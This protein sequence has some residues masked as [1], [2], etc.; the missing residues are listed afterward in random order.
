MVLSTGEIGLADHMRSARLAPRTMAGQ[1]L[2]LIDLDA[3]AG[4]GMG[5]FEQLHGAAGAAEFA[6]AIKEA[7]AKDYGLAGPLFVRR[8]IA[9]GQPSG[10]RA[11]E[12]LADFVAEARRGGDSGQIHRAALRFG[13]VAAAGELATELGI[14]P[15]PAGTAKAAALSLFNRWAEGFGR[16]G[17]MEE[18]QVI[19]AVRNAIQ[20]HG[21]RFGTVTE[22][23]ADD[24]EGNPSP[25]AGE[26]RSLST[27][28]FVHCIEMEPV[29]LFH[30]AGWEEVLKGF[31]LKFAAKA[32]AKAG[33]LW[34][35]RG[36]RHKKKVRAG[37]GKPEPFYVI[38]AS[39]LEYDEEEGPEAEAEADAVAAGA[40]WAGPE[41]S[42]LDDWISDEDWN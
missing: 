10:A 29:Y 16:T 40:V 35:D 8:I 38:R 32:L 1:E 33:Y 26:A 37:K 39:I 12:L 30:S 5:A 15:W 42:P 31:D 24:E 25:R 4:A 7:A 23:R 9:R 19:I 28:G 14:L 13:A 3:D 20:Q 36:N 6:D 21:A 22:R 17:L 11:K 18:R 34:T 41:S 27:L 2:R